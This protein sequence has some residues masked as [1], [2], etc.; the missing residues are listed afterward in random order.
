MRSSASSTEREIG[1]VTAV[2]NFRVTVSLDPDVRSPVRAYPHHI[3]TVTQVG[4]Y[5]LFP[6]TPGEHVVGII[7]GAYENEAIEPDEDTGMTLQ[8][9]RARRLLRVNLLGQLREQQPFLPGVSQYPPLESP[10]LLPTDEELKRILE[11]QP[12]PDETARDIAL[13]LG[14]S[15]LYTRQH[16]TASFNDLL[17]RPLGIVGNTGSGKS[18]SV[19]S[20][21]QA[22]LAARGGSARHAKFIILDING[23]YTRAFPPPSASK[24]GLPRILNTAS[25]NGE[26]FALPLW[27]FNLA[28]QVAF[29][30]ASQ[31]SQVPVLERVLT[32]VREKAVDP[33]PARRL[34]EVVHLVDKCRDCLSELVVLAGELNGKAVCDNAAEVVS[35]LQH[36]AGLVTEVADHQLELPV[37]ISNIA[38]CAQKLTVAGLK[39]AKDYKKLRDAKDYTGFQRMEPTLAEAVN[40]L[41]EACEPAFESARNTTI[42]KGGLTEVTADSPIPFDPAELDRDVLFR[43]AVSRYRGQERI[44]EYIATLRLRIHRQLSDKRWS[45]FTS[46]EQLSFLQVLERLTGRQGERVVVV[47]CSALAH[48][49]L[50]FFCAVFGRLVLELRQHAG[51]QARIVQPFTLVLEEAHNYLRP[52]R[53]DESQGL[54]LAREAF[55]RIAKEGRKFGLS[56]VIAS[57]RPSDVSATVLSQCANFL[58]HR[59]QNPEDIDYFKKILPTGS[60]DVLDQLPILAPGDGLL[61]GSAVNVPARV[62]ITHPDPH[63][64][65]ETPRPWEAWQDSKPQF[66]T[67][68]AANAWG[69]VDTTS[70]SP[71]LDNEKPTD[72]GSTT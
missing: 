45:V 41:V 59:I 52:H 53:D 16:V 40:R 27:C 35:A 48:D 68:G 5:V 42:S 11:F 67:S 56:L 43:L 20:L 61:L 50:P 38:S 31:V 13:P 36:Y 44:Q 21:I 32:S 71:K 66:D 39:S 60:R 54:R 2:S 1:R 65:S 37:E 4:G 51:P 69:Y 46:L 23:E 9:V 63:P 24:S 34:R 33:E 12:R 57:Q 19:A 58:I 7:V 8:L 49:V 55:E 22:A 47:D 72:P 70:P 15:P 25:I 18:Y 14:L 10:A 26:R 17:G 62:R 28:E 3:A 6:V 30:E 29:F 64:E